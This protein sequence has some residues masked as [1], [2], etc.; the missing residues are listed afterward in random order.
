MNI[1]SHPWTQFSRKLKRAITNP[2]ASGFFTEEYAKSHEMRLVVGKEE[3]KGKKVALYWLIDESDGIIADAKFQVLGG[4]SLIGICEMVCRLIIR[5]NH[6]QASRMGADLIEKELRDKRDTPSL[7]ASCNEDLNLIVSAMDNAVHQCLDIP[8]SHEYDE[9]P[10]HFSEGDLPEGGISDWDEFPKEKR[11][12]ILEEVIAKEIRPYIELDAGGIEVRDLN[13]S[14][15]TVFFSGSCSSCYSA[16][17]ST[18]S[19][20]QQILQQRIHPAITVVPEFE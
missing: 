2:E 7:P 19:A 1:Q 5:K 10:I 6:D 12:H 9:T 18:L 20:I 15:L 3:R 4:P 8:F 11:I 14:E 16:T 17:G 13:G